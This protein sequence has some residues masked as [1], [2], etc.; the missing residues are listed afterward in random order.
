MK[1][2]VDFMFMC[3]LSLYL[4]VQQQQL[5]VTIYLTRLPF[6]VYLF[7]DLLSMQPLIA[8]EGWDFLR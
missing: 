6:L 7:T 1:S 5:K 4:C 2:P 3:S 8:N